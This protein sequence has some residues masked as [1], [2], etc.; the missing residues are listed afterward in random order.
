MKTELTRLFQAAQARWQQLGRRDQLALLAAASICGLAL[1]WWVLLLPATQTLR[2]S[3]AQYQRL[4]A[5]L[6]QMQRLQAQAQALK[7][8]PPV[9]PDDAMNALESSV[10]QRFGNR[11]QLIASGGKVTLTLKAVQADTLAQW[12][13]QA[14]VNSHA[15]ILEARLTRNPPALAQLTWDGTIVLDLPGQ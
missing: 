2:H 14:R 5:Q 10:R 6:Q 13:T 4:D 15:R 9:R 7:N 11:A 12:M 3:A 1:V 8:R